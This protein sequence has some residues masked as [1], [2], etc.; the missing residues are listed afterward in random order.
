MFYKHLVRELLSLWLYS[1]KDQGGDNHL[2]PPSPASNFIFSW[3]YKPNFFNLQYMLSTF[4]WLSLPYT[5]FS[6]AL[7]PE[8]YSLLI[9]PNPV[10]HSLKLT[11]F[12]NSSCTSSIVHLINF[13][14]ISKLLQ[15]QSPVFFSRLD[16]NVV[17]WI[18]GIVELTILPVSLSLHPV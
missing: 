13:V 8:W 14:F 12:Q 16:P 9:H 3:K 7:Y 11:W 17:P 4:L 1:Y 15:F 6:D 2:F 18:Y 5:L 10:S